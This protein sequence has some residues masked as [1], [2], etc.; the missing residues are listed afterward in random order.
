MD[1]TTPLVAWIFLVSGLTVGALLAVTAGVFAWSQRHLAREAKRWGL[2]LLDAQDQERQRIAR[3]LHDDMVPRLYAAQLA[4]ERRASGEASVQIG[5]TMR[6]LRTLAHDLHP[7]A[8]KHLDLRQALDDL[9][10]RHGGPGAPVLQA[11]TAPDVALDGATTVALYRV[12]QEG[13]W[14][15]L[16]HGQPASVRISVDTLNG[17]ARLTVVDDGRG[18]SPE[19][20][21]ASFGLRSMRE[22]IEAVGGRLSVHSAPGR[23]TRVVAEVPH[24]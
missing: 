24:R 15:A 1:D 6:D 20:Q 22:R 8:L 12:A 23:G 7:P 3:D 4:L 21:G 14:N 11:T 18:F 19:Q 16:R 5:A 13:L 9:L 10:D 2:H 17:S